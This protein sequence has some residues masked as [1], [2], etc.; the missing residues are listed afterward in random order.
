MNKKLN[1]YV[2]YLLDNNPSPFCDYIICKELLKLDEKTVQDSYEWAKRFKLYTE[3]R[4]EQFPDGSWGDFYPMNTKPE[5]RKKHKV[6]GRWTI[7]RLHDLSLD[8]SDEM[9]AKMLDLCKKIIKGETPITRDTKHPQGA[10]DVLHDFCPDDE[11]VAH[12]KDEKI[13]SEDK[14][15]AFMIYKWDH[16]PWDCCKLSDLIPPDSSIFATW[17]RGLE[18][19]QDNSLF[20]EFMEPE[21]APYLYSL[22]ERLINPHDNIPIHVTRYYGKVGQYSEEWKNN[23]TKKKDLMLRILRILNKCE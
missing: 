4:D 2:N 7:K 8:A 6:T 16:A 18:E 11:L 5:V 9:V 20:G 13:I 10:Y 14:K 17:I 21:V 1:S 19:L 23:D 22:C 3:I 12:I 15:R